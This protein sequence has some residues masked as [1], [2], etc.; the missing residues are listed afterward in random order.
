[1]SAIRNPSETAS[2]AQEVR[3]AR[4]VTINDLA[5]HLGMSKSTVSRAMNGYADISE[6][7]RKRVA[8]TAQ[9]LG[10]QPL[11]HAQAIRTG[12]VRALAL[13]LQMDEPDRHNPFLQEFLMGAC[14]TASGFGWTLTVSTAT[15]DADMRDVLGRLIDERKADG[16]ILPRTEVR[17]ARVALLRARG[18]PHVLFGRTEHGVPTAKQKGSWYDI[19]GEAA[20]CS[21]VTR[22]AGLGHE[23]IGYVGST[24]NFNYTH[25]RRE[26]FKAGLVASGLPYD[27]SLLRE[28]ARTREEG[29]REVR[30]LMQLEHPP[31]GV[32]FATDMAALG[33]Y[34][35]L[36]DL[37]LLVG[38]DVS[39]IGYDGVPEAEYV[40]PG[41]TTYQ[42]DTRR[43]GAR[44]AE[45]L[46][47]QI[48][49]EAPEALREVS[50]AI[51]VERQSDG[52]PAL[53]SA[54]LAEKIENTK[55]K[56][57]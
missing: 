54:Q 46:I 49:G 26:G 18:V 43:A 7:T 3:T 8:S 36:N 47:R 53:T 28:G 19:L 10:Y 11:S 35:A 27:A 57:T 51:L 40:R 9:K 4:R 34:D 25:L 14:E 55:T 30:A 41:L 12:R 15:S 2:P 16:F 24:A 50:D 29:A 13:V 37:G 1:M 32:V 39:V 48:R 21:A 6:S 38:K 23:R 20:M 52:P 44:L 31:T 56:N 5:A 22:L 17:D 42:V 45:L 33:G